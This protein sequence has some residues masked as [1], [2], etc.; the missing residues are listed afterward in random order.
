MKKRYLELKDIL[1]SLPRI[2][3]EQ[4][5]EECFR[6]LQEKLKELTEYRKSF[7]EE[8]DKKQMSKYQEILLSII[9]E[10]Y[11]CKYVYDKPRGYAGD[12]ITQEMIWYAHKSGNSH[13]YLGQTD[14][15]K[16]LSSLTFKME[17]SIANI[18]R[19]K[20]IKKKV[21]ESGKQIASIGCGSCIEFWHLKKDFFKYKDIFLLDQDNGALEQVQRHLK[22]KKSNNIQYVNENIL[23]FI[24]I[25]KHNN[26]LGKRDLIYLIGL[27]DYFYVKSAKKLISALWKNVKSGGRLFFSNAHPDNPTRLWMEYGGEW[28]ICYKEEKDM[29]EIVEDLDNIEKINFKKDKYNVYQYLEVIKK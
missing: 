2:A 22:S 24:A 3:Q 15:G 10:S 23:K 19:L 13:R 8:Q 16:I 4:G 12:Y 29:Y 27:M 9:H 18:D 6:I 26:L 5:E 20:Y 7:D 28:F 25:N 11:F 17:N 1:L 21:K 14:V